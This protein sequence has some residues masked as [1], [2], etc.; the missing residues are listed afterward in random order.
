MIDSRRL[1]LPRTVLEY[2]ANNLIIKIG[3]FVNKHYQGTWACEN[4]YKAE[5]TLTNHIL[6]PINPIE[7]ASDAYVY[8]CS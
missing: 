7:N 3:F 6:R 4:M 5:T 8:A 1:L 2:K